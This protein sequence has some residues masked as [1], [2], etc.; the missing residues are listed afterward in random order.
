MRILWIS[1]LLSGLLLAAL[2]KAH[3]DTALLASERFE[4]QLSQHQL[5]LTTSHGAVV[6]SAYGEGVIMVD[7]ANGDE[8]ELPRYAL[9]EN[10]HARLGVV[11]QLADGLRYCAPQICVQVQRH[12]LQLRF[13]EAE[14]FEPISSTPLLAEERGF[15]LNGG[16]R[17]FRFHLDKDEK[18]MGGGQR[19]LGMDRRGHKLAL[20]N[21][22]AYGYGEHAEQMYYSLPAVMSSKRYAL[23][24]DN[25]AD[26]SLDLGHTEPDIL[27]FT[28]EAGRTS[29]L[30]AAGHDYPTLIEN[31][32]YA[33]GRQPLPPRW[34]LGNFASRFG[35][36]TQ[37]E[38]SQ[39]VATFAQQDFPLDALVLDLFW[40]GANIKGHMGKLA[41]DKQAFPHP[42]RMIADLATAGVN[43]VLITEPFV[44]T[45]TERW[46]EAKAK[47]ALTLHANAEVAT[48]D[49]YFGHTSLIDV[50]SRAGQQWFADIYQQLMLQGVAG[51]WG[52]LGEPEVHPSHLYHRLDT[53]TDEPGRSRLVPADTLHNVYG[54]QWAS[55]LATK[56]Q[57]W[58]PQQRPLIMMRS[59]YIGSQRYGMIPWTGDVERSWSGLRPQVELSLQMGVFGLGY[60]HS[61]LGGFAGG[62]QFD[63]ELY[64]RWLQYGVFQPVYRP[65]AQDHIAPEPVFHSEQVQNRLRP[66]VKLRY[67]LLPYIYTLAYQNSRYGWPLMRPLMFL[68]PSQFDNKDSYLFGDAM[69]VT[70]VVNPEVKQVAVALPK[71]VWFDYFTGARF[72]GGQTIAQAVSLETLPVLVRAGS[73]IPWLDNPK[74]PSGQLV[75]SQDYQTHTLNVDYYFDLEISASQ[76]E[77][78]DD[79]GSDPHSLAN[80]Q[81]ELLRFESHL[82]KDKL[83]IKLSSQGQARWP[84]GRQ[85]NLNVRHLTAKPSQITVNGEPQALSW[86]PGRLT[87]PVTLVGQH[88]S[89]QLVVTLGR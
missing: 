67:Q 79:D 29:Y 80:G 11:T 40:F 16:K 33:I 45:H 10:R 68:D 41:W 23:L 21:R 2:S 15:V 44:L 85:I 51:W 86:Q 87:V 65:H 26:G 62:E 39:T 4:W 35:Y 38:V 72:I 53:P 50:F 32:T 9:D 43:T 18:L 6:I 27:A 55:M 22:A 52:D 76:G 61:D 20:Y 73:F 89:A 83:T 54:H 47:L 64:S 78:F 84:G 7:Y 25:S 17:G 24:I 59:G 88:A 3:A 42:E 57:Q 28:A 81:Y 34:A 75:S 49:F 82:V 46:Q 36:R 70:P 14:Q 12:P 48:F 5:R 8:I 60:T 30:V 13:F 56:L 37:A 31:M 69:L 71:G 19:V 63:P 58:Q 66:F 77:M 1:L 74:K